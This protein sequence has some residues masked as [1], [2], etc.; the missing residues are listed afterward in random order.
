MKIQRD[1]TLEA[2]DINFIPLIDVLLV[3]V[4][5]LVVTTTYVRQSQLKVELPG[6]QNAQ[7]Q[8]SQAPALLIR[9]GRDGNYAL[10]GSGVLNAAELQNRLQTQWAN[11][12]NKK[13]QRVLLEADSAASHQ[14]VVTAMD[15]LAKLGIARVGIA[16]AGKGN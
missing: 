10:E 2:P 4:I 7:Q 14:A 8:N 9:I 15:V 16:T 12:P 11:L 6:T 13:E 5:F 3:I 1:T